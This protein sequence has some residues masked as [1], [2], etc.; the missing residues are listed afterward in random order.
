MIGSKRERDKSSIESCNENN[1]SSGSE[2]YIISSKKDLF[3]ICK[4]KGRKALSDELKKLKNPFTILDEKIISEFNLKTIN[5]EEGHSFE[6][7][8]NFS[9]VPK[10]KI[11]FLNDEE[12][13]N[14]YYD[15]IKKYKNNIIFSSLENETNNTSEFDLE[16]LK[17]FLNFSNNMSKECNIID[18]C[19]DYKILF[20]DNSIEKLYEIVRPKRSHIFRYHVY[21]SQRVIMKYFSPRKTC[22]S[23]YSR[24]ILAN[25]HFKKKEFIPTLI[26]DVAFIFN[27]ITNNKHL[28]KKVIN[29]EI[30]SLFNNK[31]DID[32]FINIID[33]SISETMRFIEN[34][35][36]LYLKYMN[37]NNINHKRPLFCL[38]NYSYIYDKEKYLENI[39]KTS[40]IK[41][42]Y[43]LYIIYSIIDQEDQKEYVKNCI[44]EQNFNTQFTAT[45]FPICYL[46]N[47][48]NI[49]EIENNLGNDGYK[50]PDE[51]K[52]IFGQNSYFLFKFIK[53]GKKFEDFVKKETN[54]IKEELNFFYCKIQNKKIVIENLIKTIDNKEIF[55]VE[56]KNREF[57]KNLLENI[58]SNYIV[59]NREKGQ[60]SEHYKY[61]FEYCFPL[62]KSI[63]VLLSKTEFFIDIN[64][65]DFLKL[66][67]TARSINFDENINYYF[68]NETSF[69]GYNDCE[70]EK[71]FDEYCLEANN[72][73]NNGD[74]IYEY[75]KVINILK[76]NK[77]ETL[78]NLITKY[79]NKDLLHDKKLI[80]VFQKFRGKFVDIL[81]LV[82]KEENNNF[83]IVN[84][85]IKFSDSFRILKKDKRQ[86][87]FQMTYLK[88]KYHYIF[89]INIIDSY[90]IYLSLY[91]DR[92][93]FAEK[94]P[95]IVILFSKKIKKIVDG[96][97]E[98]LKKFP[99]LKR[100][101]VPLIS[102]FDKFVDSFKLMLQNQFD[103]MLI[104]KEIE[105]KTDQDII[106]FE[107]SKKE[108]TISIIFRTL[109]SKTITENNKKFK[110]GIICYSII[111][112]KDAE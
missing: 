48:R 86:Q 4:I 102:E 59:I 101:K 2:K 20:P 82:K 96:N 43:N 68:K 73:D 50:I 51:Y 35:I 45:Q 46:P 97:G 3:V 47:L 94:N 31:I 76:S 98:E 33:F 32:D 40:K 15:D 28:L 90:I 17:K 103:K 25:I 58:P 29:H 74:Q 104:F 44:D 26:F 13:I 99:F 106:K 38:D 49:S 37:D 89:G 55:C 23:L 87:P 107:I 64:H 67:D 14:N 54:C 109:R 18:F 92:K 36:M 62:I 61:S 79:K 52:S 77:S 30:I 75:N 78:L 7:K 5:L 21:D 1:S 42:D 60:N 95:D 65:P 69:F 6:K 24:C 9:T 22:K 11:I 57:L 85:Q 91:E 88:E 12:K 16:F 71:A 110:E 70:I 34:I 111:E 100:A 72:I 27:N 53:E 83:S 41:S 80:V 39:E 19:L 112:D 66:D 108:I 81:F 8:V 56:N 105:E 93:K 63:L 84:L 10:E